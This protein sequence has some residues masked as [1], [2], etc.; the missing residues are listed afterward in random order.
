MRFEWDSSKAQGN[1]DKHGVT[2]DESATVLE[3]SLSITI[4]DPIHSQGEARFV[5][6]GVS[7]RGKTLVVVHTERG[8]SIRIISARLASA[9][10]RRKY[11]ES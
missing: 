7:D 8:E 11:A 6:I 2:F 1:L 3:D 9:A 10:E 5:T 4:P